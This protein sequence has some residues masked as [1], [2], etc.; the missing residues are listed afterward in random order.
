MPCATSRSRAWGATSSQSAWM[1]APWTGARVTPARPIA[2]SPSRMGAARIVSMYSGVIRWVPKDHLNQMGPLEA[3]L[4]GTPVA[5]LS[6]PVEVLRVVHSFDPCLA[7][8]VHLVRP[9]QRT[10]GH[11]VLIGS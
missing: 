5:D 7:C 8:A 3:A 9:G 1:S 4:V 10:A 2:P 11:K 6:Q